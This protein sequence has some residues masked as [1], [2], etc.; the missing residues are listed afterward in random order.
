MENQIQKTNYALLSLSGGLDSTSTLL[1]LLDPNIKKYEEIFTYSFS[2][3]QKHSKEIKL[4]K[5]NVKYLNSLIENGKL[6]TQV[7]KIHHT[8]IDLKSIFE[9]T[10]S[11]LLGDSGKDIPEG[12]YQESNQKSTVVPIRNIIFSSI[13]YSKASG[14]VTRYLENLSDHFTENLNGDGEDEKRGCILP[15]VD[16]I[17]GIHADDNS[18]GYPDCRPESVKMA[19]ELY[20]ISDYNAKYIEYISPFVNGTKGDLLSDGLESG[21][22]IGLSK[23]QI[24][25]ILKNTITC[26]NPNPKTGESCGRCASCN[27]RKDAFKYVGME[28]PIKYMSYVVKEGETPYIE[29]SKNGTRKYVDEDYLRR[30]AESNGKIEKIK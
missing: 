11:S 13:L 9:G 1:Y 15:Q 30:M 7:K 28:D 8:I 19:Q 24:K 20:K 26:Y 6:R 22:R 18:D 2:Y 4:A 14:I 5:N 17:L 23:P 12:K 27:S 25:R 16:I 3:G 29:D 10:G 21:I